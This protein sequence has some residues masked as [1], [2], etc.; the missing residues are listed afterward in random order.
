MSKETDVEE[1][2]KCRINPTYD[3]AGS[4]AIALGIYLGL[5]AIAESIKERK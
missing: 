2:K 5:V 1:I 4:E 3:E